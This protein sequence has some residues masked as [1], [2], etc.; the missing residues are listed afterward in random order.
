MR[1]KYRRRGAPVTAIRLTLETEGLVYQKWG[2][3]QVGKPGDWI[4]DNDGDIYTV[5]A[6]VFER[7][8]ES[9]GVGRYV[10]KTSVWAMRAEQGGAVATL[11]G[12]THYLA[13]DYIVWNDEHGLDA[14]AVSA[15]KFEQLYE[16]DVTRSEHDRVH[17][18]SADDSNASETDAI[19][20]PGF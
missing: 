1:Q 19:H 16:L 13:G 3:A 14:Y 6:T 12:V 17:A 11:E 5:D 15:D 20:R 10:K 4:V 18:G 2:G 8:Y 7:T 9:I